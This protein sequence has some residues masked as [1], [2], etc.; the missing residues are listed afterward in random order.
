MPLFNFIK[1]KLSILDVVG[2]Y[3]QLKP[4][5]SYWKAP[6]PFHYE[7]EASFT[8]SPDRRRF[9]LFCFKN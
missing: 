2:E 4:A 5:G 8:I 6:C 9:D 7:K 1:S 3:V